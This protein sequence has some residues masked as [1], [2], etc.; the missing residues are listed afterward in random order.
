MLA[1]RKHNIFLMK[2]LCLL[3]LLPLRL[4]S[5]L[6]TDSLKQVILKLPDDTAKVNKLTALSNKVQ[7]TAPDQ[8]ISILNAAIVLAKKL[9]Y[10]YGLSVAYGALAIVYCNRQQLDSCKLFTDKAHPLVEGKADKGSRNQK[11]VLL[12]NYGIIHH[13]KQRL[14][15][16]IENYIAATNIFE[17]TQNYKRLVFSYL[18]ISSLYT[19]LSDTVKYEYY[20]RLAYNT[21]QKTNDT[22]VLLR[23]IMS[24][25]NLHSQSERYDSAAMY[26]RQGYQLAQK[27]N[28]SFSSGKFCV[29][30]ADA[31]LRS[32]HK[33]DSAVFYLQKAYDYTR[34]LNTPYDESII[35]YELGMV[36]KEK[37]DY[38]AAIKYFTMSA[39]MQ[40]KNQLDQLLL[41]SLQELS[42]AEEKAGNIK[43]ALIHNREF[44]VTYDS[45]NAR[46]NRAKTD[47][48]EAK[49]Q[50]RLKDEQLLLQQIKLKSERLTKYILASAVVALLILFFMA[51]R[52]YMHKRNLQQQ[53]I[54]ELEKEKLL[55]ATQSIL[56]GQE[57]ERSRMA[58]D[59]HDGLGGLL[60]GVKLQ[61]GAMKGNLILSEEHGR[62]FNNALGKLD[63]SIS[64]MRRV[65]HNMM[66]EALMKLSLQQALQDY[67]D[68]LSE[69]QAFKINGEF[70]GLEKRMDSSTEIVVYRIVQELLNNVVKHSDATAI[71]AQVMRN[72]NNLSITVEDNGKGF[73]MTQ[74]DLLKGTGLNNIQSRV[75]YLK[76]Q[77][78][79]QSTPG[80]GTSVHIDCIIENNG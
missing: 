75:D 27:V 23:G 51:Y 72:D 39:D 59:L 64:E 28:E 48:L 7:H 70:Y 50:T 9:K 68:G 56:K 77:L 60:S 14:D 61:L 32:R 8:S 37:K 78:D 62:T 17:E 29:I 76:G 43:D 54:A 67:C 18:N 10:D 4:F 71:L 34:H 58:K 52:N 25:A 38:P 45:V 40:R 35:L 53:K 36:Y 41:Y 46:N 65:A 47:E 66:P 63:E 3:L 11:A 30:I 74:S 26:A 55:S 44:L 6:E 13:Y 79:I 33:Y 1:K 69:S 57:E 12:M 73:D 22:L 42:D 16:A 20:A 80:K 24:V 21:S 15:S 2:S 49:Y 19:F 5:Q 31:L